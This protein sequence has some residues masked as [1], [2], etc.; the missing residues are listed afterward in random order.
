MTRGARGP[1]EGETVSK[2]IGKG[3]PNSRGGRGTSQIGKHLQ[4]RGKVR[5]YQRPLGTT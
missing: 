4:I 5:Q 1:R 3:G 2:S